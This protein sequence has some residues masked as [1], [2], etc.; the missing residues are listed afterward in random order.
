MAAAATLPAPPDPTASSIRPLAAQLR[1][2]GRHEEALRT[3][4]RHLR[5]SS[6][7]ASALNAAARLC[8]E[9]ALSSMR[10]GEGEG[11]SLDAAFEYLQVSLGPD[12]SAVWDSSGLGPTGLGQES[13]REGEV[14]SWEAG[15]SAC[16]LVAMHVPKSV[17]CGCCSKL[18]E[19]RPT[20]YDCT[21]CPG[22]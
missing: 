11:Y 13:R 15:E 16:D 4:G 6:S 10:E 14:V 2:E 17:V 8:N 20:Y 7:S 19:T 21:H 12:I 3:I 5:A 18:R 9:L 1:N 22:A